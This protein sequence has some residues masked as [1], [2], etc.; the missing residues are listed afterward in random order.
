MPRY[1]SIDPARQPRLRFDHVSASR[2]SF[3]A[4]PK[5]CSPCAYT[6]NVEQID[7]M[8]E[9]YGGEDVLHERMR[10]Y[11]DDAK[12]TL[13]DVHKELQTYTGS[14]EL[15]EPDEDL[16]ATIQRIIDNEVNHVPMR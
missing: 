16:R 9:E 2:S 4:G 6:K 5:P 13:V 12:A 10:G 7:A 15:P 3:S 14:F 1:K 8:T 11:L